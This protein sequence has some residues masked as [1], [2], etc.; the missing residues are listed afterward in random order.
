MSETFAG[1]IQLARDANEAAHLVPPLLQVGDLVLVKG[2]RAVGLELVCQA[3][4][5]GDGG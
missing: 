1:R 5:N 3:L 2:S 4:R